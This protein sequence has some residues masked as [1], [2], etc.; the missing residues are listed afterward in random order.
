MWSRISSWAG[1]A[2]A[3]AGIVAASAALVV[4]V[5]P[6]NRKRPPAT[7]SP[8]V[9]EELLDLESTSLMLMTPS[10]SAVTF[11]EGDA[12]AA[13]AHLKARV[14]SLISTYPWL[15]G[16]LIMQARTARIHLTF[17]VLPSA[18][19]ISA[20][21]A[22]VE[23]ETLCEI[24]APYGKLNSAFARFCVPAG[25]ATLD[26]KGTQ[27]LFRVTLVRST[28]APARFATVVSI[29]H[30]IADGATF[31]SLVGALSAAQAE[32]PR[33][34]LLRRHHQFSAQLREA[35]G[36]NNDTLSWLTGAGATLGIVRT[37]LLSPRAIPLVAS[38]NQ[39]WINSEKAKAAACTSS[40]QNP[41]GYVSTN[42]II[43]SSLL[44]AT[45][46]DVGVMAVNFRRRLESIA[47]ESAGNYEALVAY[48]KGDF[49]LPSLLRR[50]LVERRNGGVRRVHGERSLPGLLSAAFFTSVTLVSTWATFYT[51]LVL[52]F[53]TVRSHLPLVDTST[54]PFADIAI[55]FRPDAGRMAVLMLSRSLTAES[56]AAA[57]GGFVKPV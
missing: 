33:P 46:C 14:A 54:V 38:V 47:V 31:Y 10:V 18:A 49:E 6:R 1:F 44:R 22:D 24:D 42:D 51:E 12:E 35:L 55:I 57:L 28:S 9:T 56:L 5:F 7:S 41:A 3:T 40:T 23:V 36:A 19:A 8:L 29:S 32:P 37:L 52:P 21:F 26:S 34:L 53:S 50:S 15:A 13:V 4:L 25:R 45:D 43:T 48:N 30:V 2:A 39:S 16:T 27:A 17:P 11:Y 20:A